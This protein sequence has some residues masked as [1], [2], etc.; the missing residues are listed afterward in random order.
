MLRVLRYWNKLSFGRNPLK[1]CHAHLIKLEAP[2]LERKTPKNGSLIYASMPY[3]PH[4]WFGLPHTN[5]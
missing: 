4:T 3:F 5:N 2:K 1:G